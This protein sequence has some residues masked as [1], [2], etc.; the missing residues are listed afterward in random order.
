MKNIHILPT[1]KPSR[2]YYADKK[3]YL[4]KDCIERI[5]YQVNIYITNDEKIKEG[6]WIYGLFNGG[7]IIK[8]EFDVPKNSQY[9]KEYGL[10]IILTTDTQLIKDG[11]QKID[12]EFLEWFVAHP[13]C[14]EID[15][16]KYMSGEYSTMTK[17]E[18]TKCY[19]GHTTT[20]DCGPEEP[21]QE[22]LEEAAVIYAHKS[23]IWPLNKQGE[24]QSIPP[25]QLVPPGYAKHQKVATK[26]FTNGAKWQQEQDKKLYSE[27]DLE[28]AFEQGRLYSNICYRRTFKNV[29]EI[30]QFKKK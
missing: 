6:D 5:N 28:Y 20:C 29:L 21:K 24:K 12:D 15:Y 22:T 30:L 4:H 17:E 26:H 14:E 11:V 18:Q 16:W 25:G 19:C 3:L 23:F 9:Y 13:S 27:E 8:S 7:V 2:L 10:K 1:D